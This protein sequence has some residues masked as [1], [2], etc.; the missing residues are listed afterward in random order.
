MIIVILALFGLCLG[1]FVNALVWRVHEQEKGQRA[2]GKDLSILRGRSICP[3]CRHTLYTKDLFP[4]FSW[5]SLSGHCRYCGRHISWQY[6]LVE[7]STAVVFV[8]SYFYWPYPLHGGQWLIFITW[9]IVS[10]GL[11]ALL[12]YDLLWMLLPNRILY[13]T[14]LVALAGRISYLVF[15]QQDKLHSLVLLGLSIAVSS[16]LFWLLF[17]LSKGRWIGY[18]DVRLGLITGVVLAR[19]SLSVLMIFL[20]SVLGTIF[21]LP[22]LA[23]GRTKMASKIPF[24][25][26]LIAGT[27]I[28]LLIGPPLVD[29]YSQVLIP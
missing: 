21:I 20:A 5:L 3:H 19:P 10:V 18:G 15:Y 16:G 17:V 25:P 26:F 28:A 7:A 22:S 24:G 6:P 12:V 14:L 27:F 23:S 29:W 4:L 13:P 11:M 9:L 8:F 1:S 2:K